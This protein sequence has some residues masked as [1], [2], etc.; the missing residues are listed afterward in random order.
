MRTLLFLFCTLAVWGCYP[1][2]HH[3]PKVLLAMETYA[4]LKGQSAALKKAASQF[5]AFAKESKKN[6][7]KK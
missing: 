2:Q 3:D 1:Q 5:P 4:F 6:G 7:L